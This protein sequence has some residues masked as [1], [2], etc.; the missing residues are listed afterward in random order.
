L[1]GIVFNLAQ[2]VITESYGED[3]W[4]GLLDS[5]GLE[6]SY[7]SLGNYPDG[8]LAALVGAAASAL[9]LPPADIVRDLGRGAMPRLAN[10]YPSFFEGHVSTESFLLTLNEIIHAEVR[11]LY[12]DAALPTFGFDTSEPGALVLI[13]DSKR[14]LC[15]LAEGFIHGA[16]A[17]FGEHA[18]IT[19]AECMDRGD[20]RCLL[21]CVFAPADVHPD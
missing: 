17:R 11:K 1:K 10:R 13:Y 16:A 4:D 9:D 12:P 21:R 5:A 2:E 7:T 19:Q 20:A 3:T 8:D 15:A 6:G 18:V 14:R